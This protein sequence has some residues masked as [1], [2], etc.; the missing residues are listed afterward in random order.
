M[1]LHQRYQAIVEEFGDVPEL[2]RELARTKQTLALAFEVLDQWR[3]TA[4]RALCYTR[5]SLPAVL[6]HS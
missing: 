4:G 5:R 6:I 2:Q 3:Q 1:R